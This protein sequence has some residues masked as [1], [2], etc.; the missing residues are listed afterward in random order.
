MEKKSPQRDNGVVTLK[1]KLLDSGKWSKKIFFTRISEEKEG[2]VW[3][4]NLFQVVCN[5]KTQKF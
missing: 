3:G 2:K 1:R 5:V 4:P